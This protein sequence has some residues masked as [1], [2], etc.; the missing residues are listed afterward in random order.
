MM[1]ACLIIQTPAERDF[2]FLVSHCGSSQSRVEPVCDDSEEN[3]NKCWNV[4]I[5]GDVW[6][7]LFWKTFSQSRF[8]LIF[9]VSLESHQI[10]EGIPEKNGFRFRS[11]L[12]LTV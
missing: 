12:S 4:N 3:E 10:N 2:F 7:S 8:F 9:N 1:T 5:P 11:H 6:V